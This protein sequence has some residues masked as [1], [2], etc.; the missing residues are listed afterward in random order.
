MKRKKSPM[1][2]S[3]LPPLAIRALPLF[4]ASI[5]PHLDASAAV[6]VPFFVAVLVLIAIAGELV[7]AGLPAYWCGLDRRHALGVGAGMSARGAVQLIIADIASRAGLFDYPDPPP[8]VVRYMFSA[9]VLMALIT[10]LTTPIVLQ[11][12]LGRPRS[13]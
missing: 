11:Q 12:V 5:G 1:S 6:Q 10:T 4:F 3:T 7:G 8:D 2:T 9:V 13:D